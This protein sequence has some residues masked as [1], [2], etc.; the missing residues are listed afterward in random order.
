VPTGTTPAVD[1]HF[2]V[3]VLTDGRK[4]LAVSLATGRSHLLVETPRPVRAQIDDVGVVYTYNI[5]RSGFL[6]FLPFGKVEA[7]LAR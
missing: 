3:A 4:V 5:G 7:A 1:V 2:G 6:G